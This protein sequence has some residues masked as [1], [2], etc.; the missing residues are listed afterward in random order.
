VDTSLEAT[1]GPWG[2]MHPVSHTERPHTPEPEP[3]RMTQQCYDGS[4]WALLRA[5]R[6]LPLLSAVEQLTPKQ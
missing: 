4:L 3:N 5:A 1:K 2:K 6:E